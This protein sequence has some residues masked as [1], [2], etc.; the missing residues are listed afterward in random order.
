MCAR[1]KPSTAMGLYLSDEAIIS[2]TIVLGVVL[3]AIIQAALALW[4]MNKD[5]F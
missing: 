2:L 4:D 3:P 1:L 5:R